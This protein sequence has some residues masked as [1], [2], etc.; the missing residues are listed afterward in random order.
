VASSDPGWLIDFNQDLADVFWANI[1]GNINALLKWMISRREIGSRCLE[2]AA[3]CVLCSYTVPS[4]L[5]PSNKQ[6]QQALASHT[7]FEC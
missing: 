1:L 4:L 6:A 7:S 3:I 5:L 2:T